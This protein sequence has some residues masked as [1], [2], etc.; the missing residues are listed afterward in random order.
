MVEEAEYFVRMR[1]SEQKCVS[2]ART[3]VCDVG[4]GLA[5][6]SSMQAYDKT[7]LCHRFSVAA[8]AFAETSVE[9]YDKVFIKSLKI[10]EASASS[11]SMLATPVHGLGPVVCPVELA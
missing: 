2:T 5:I 9:F 11:A 1:K 3:L 4:G 6:A 10:E 8:G 7:A